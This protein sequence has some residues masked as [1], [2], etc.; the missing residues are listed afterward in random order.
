VAQRRPKTAQRA[1]PRTAQKAAPRT[2]QTTAQRKGPGDLRWT[3]L[4]D[5]LLQRAAL[6]ARVDRDRAPDPLAGLKVD[7][8]DVSLLLRELP[9]LE[10]VASRDRDELD[11]TLSQVVEEVRAAFASALTSGTPFGSLAAAAGLDRIE[12]EV[13]AV[14]CAVE[15]DPRRQRL[16]GYLNDDVGQRRLTPWSLSQLFSA[17]D[18]ALRAI[19][20]GGGLRS[21]A[22]LSP[23]SDG[24][25]ATTTLAVAQSVIWW[26]FGDGAPDPDLPPGCEVVAGPGTG[27][28][29]LVVA[30]GPDRLRRLQAAVTAMSPRSILVAPLPDSAVAW[31]AVVRQATLAHAGVALEI[32]GGFDAAARDRVERT[33]HLSWALTSASDLP[34]ADLPRRPWCEVAVGERRATDEEWA[35]TFGSSQPKEYAL[36]AEQLDHVGRAAAALGGDI[37]GAVRRLATGHI[38]ETAVRIRPTR[39]WDDIV[40]DPERLEQLREVA[41][42]CRRRDRVFGEWG[43]SASPSTGTVALFAGPSGTGKTLAAEIIAAELGVDLYK[44]DLANLVSKYIGETEKNLSRL[45]DAAE[46]SGVALFLDEADALLGKRSEVSDA[47]DRYANIEV[48]YLLQRLERYEGVAV[49]ATNLSKNIDSAFLRRLHIVVEFPLPGPAERRRIW[50]VC[51]PSAAPR[52]TDL[53]LDALADEFEL[54]G[55]T[56]RNAV[57]SA[58]FLAAEAETSITMD[59]MVTALG[60]E[61]RKIGRLVTADAFG[62]FS[63]VASQ[64][65]PEG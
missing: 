48:A 32:S 10:G 9:G 43:F 18:G 34:L 40:L 47:H 62:A 21:A 1:A 36:S 11:E 44:V 35:A 16:V 20:P 39:G 37:P 31:D 58:A 61:M 52:G 2:A 3:D 17:S 4:A 33:T 54:S 63:D 49:L 55:G 26:L 38:D 8:E 59:L 6:V 13:M 15:L 46:G 27:T 7:D 24:P 57:L 45:F 50:E 56:I 64:P 23:P 29:R 25:W 22:L 28:E 60:R 41:V 51:F 65:D 19:A 12:S 5:V 53:D 30:S 14:L 42:R